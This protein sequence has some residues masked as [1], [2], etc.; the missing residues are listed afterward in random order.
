MTGIVAP[1]NGG[2]GTATIPTSGQ[3]PVGNAGGTA[4]AP[5]TVNGD[6]TLASTGALTPRVQAFGNGSL[7]SGT[8]T[9]S[10]AAACTPSA[11]CVYKLTNCGPSGT[12]TYPGILTVGTISVGNTFVINSVTNAAA[13]V[14]TTDTSN[15][16]WQIN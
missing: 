5:E 1:A 7:T 15:V 3:V 2:T 11:T 16:C 8:I 13:T 4:Y 9:I 6:A 12:T 10:N 14:L